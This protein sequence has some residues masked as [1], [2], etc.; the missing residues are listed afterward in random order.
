MQFGYPAV[1]DNPA[2]SFPEGVFYDADAHAPAFAQQS[3]PQA[4]AAGTT[5]TVNLAG[6][7]TDSDPGD[8]I[9]YTAASDTLQVTATVPS[10]N[11]LQITAQAGY[12]GTATVTLTARYRAGASGSPEGRTAQQRFTVLVGTGEITGTVYADSNRN[13]QYDGTDPANAGPVVFLDQ[14]HNGVLDPGERYTVADANGNYAFAGLA[15]G[16]YYLAEQPSPGWK[17]SYTVGASTVAVNGQGSV[18]GPNFGNV[19]NLWVTATAG[20]NAITGPLDE[21]T[22]I[23]L[24]ANIASGL[25]GVSYTWQVVGA[26]GEPVQ[27]LSPNGASSFTFKALDDHGGRPGHYK[28]TV[29]INSSQGPYAVD[30]HLFT[31]NVAPTINPGPGFT[32]DEGSPVTLFSNLTDPAPRTPSPTRGTWSPPMARRSPTTTTRISRSRPRTWARTR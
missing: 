26:D 18:A 10:A 30:Y 11:T 14:S 29:S 27:V 9:S 17:Q 32:T 4:V 19:Q 25:T 20:G 1:V 15:A 16:S 5:A 12:S 24:T 7:A 22:A 21:G 3:V 2:T 8:T 28:A 6:A 23:T 13:S 31:R